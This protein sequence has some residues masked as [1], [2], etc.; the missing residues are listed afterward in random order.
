MPDP[1]T[2]AYLFIGICLTCAAILGAG[3]YMV[4]AEDRRNARLRSRIDDVPYMGGESIR[5]FS[6]VGNHDGAT[7]N[8]KKA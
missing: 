4:F 6:T 3:L 2:L 5:T 7:R 1:F 8:L